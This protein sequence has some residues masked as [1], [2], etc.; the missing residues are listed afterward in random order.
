M[1]N[2]QG[3]TGVELTTKEKIIVDTKKITP[4]KSNDN[5]SGGGGSGGQRTPPGIYY[6][7]GGRAWRVDDKGNWNKIQQAP[8]GT[9]FLPVNP[10]IP[11]FGP[12]FEPIP[13]FGW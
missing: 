6:D 8:Y 13:I 2:V 12:V 1:G 3:G 5:G 10:T 4:L 11:S 9:Y 7:D